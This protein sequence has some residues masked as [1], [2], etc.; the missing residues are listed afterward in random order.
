MM[1][2]MFH[3]AYA[4]YLLSLAAGLGLFI[5]SSRNVGKGVGI[6]KF[7][8]VIIMLLSI[9][10]IACTGY[11]GTKYWQEGYFSVPTDMMHRVME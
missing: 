3:T 5:W 7:F 6:A 2:F 4:L 11:F 1:M 9:L 10:G 8:S